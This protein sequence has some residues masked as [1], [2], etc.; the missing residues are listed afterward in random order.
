MKKILFFLC[1]LIMI[2]SSCRKSNYSPYVPPPQTDSLLEWKVIASFTNRHLLD[3][4]FI[5][6]QKGFL[7]AD[8]LYQTSDG[9][10]TWTV[11]P[12]TSSVKNFY[13]LFFVNTKYGFAY[14]SSQLA[15]TVDGGATWTVKPLP[16]GVVTMFFTDA[17]TGFYS[18]RTGGSLKKTIDS[19]N[20]WKNILKNNSSSDIYYPYFFSAD[21][22]YVATGQGIFASTSDAGETWNTSFQPTI[23]SGTSMAFNSYNQ[24]LFLDRRKGFYAY[25]DGLKKTEDGGQ[26]WN[27]AMNVTHDMT[28][29]F[30]IIRF[31]DPNTGFYK[32]LTI[33][34]KT[35][36]GGQNWNMNCR[37]GDDFITGM[38]FVDGHTGWACTSRGRI[39]KLQQ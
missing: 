15:R 39:L 16:T 25:P 14:D 23:H 18:D 13:Y 3:I 22:G 12:N 1:L 36:D 9:G 28:S 10:K 8:H 7:L 33:I 24:L 38:S 6:A 20:S 29:L 11:I 27:N 34:Y 19:G 2:G 35:S 30:S 21:T 37:V 26:T 4:W 31:P 5:S 32:G 17:A